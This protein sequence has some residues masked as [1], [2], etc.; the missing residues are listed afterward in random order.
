MVNLQKTKMVKT[1]GF[2][3][4]VPKKS[5][6]FNFN[7]VCDYYPSCLHS[8]NLINATKIFRDITPLNRNFKTI[9]PWESYTISDTFHIKPFFT[10]HSTSE[11]FAF[12]NEADRKRMFYSEDFRALG[13][14]KSLQKLN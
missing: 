2:S 7:H 9:I 13:R 8:L 1:T 4:Y 6:I 5:F 3:N 11:A 12:L 10:D 14:K